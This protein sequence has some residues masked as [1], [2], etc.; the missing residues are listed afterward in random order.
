MVNITI[1]VIT[2]IMIVMVIRVVR[3][4]SSDVC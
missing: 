4:I 1:R 2:N 3:L